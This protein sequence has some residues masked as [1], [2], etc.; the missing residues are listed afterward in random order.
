M[1][2]FIYFDIGGVLVQDF[3]ATDKWEKMFSDLGII[4]DKRRRLDQIWS[5]YAPRL[6]LDLGA[7]ELGQILNRELNLNLPTNYSMLHDFISRFSQN[8][9]LWPLIQNLHHKHKLGLLTNMYPNMLQKIK[10][11]RLL[12]PVDWSVIID[13]STV[14]FQKPE[15]AIF[16]LAIKKAGVPASQILFVDNTQENIIAADKL[17][18]QTFWYD[19]ANYENSS[20]QLGEYISKRS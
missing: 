1:I 3:S 17:K 12:P 16:K 11:A 14:G 2:Q 4:G 8:R 18:L 9:F 6:S 15:P 5:K 19:S 13:S 20:Q 7:D 10:T